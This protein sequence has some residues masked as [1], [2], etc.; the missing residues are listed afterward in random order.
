VWRQHDG[1]GVAG[2]RRLR[3]GLYVDAATTGRI[4][5]MD[6]CPAVLATALRTDAALVDIV[7]GKGLHTP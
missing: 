4:A 7:L 3:L 1:D 2:P 5:K 6:N